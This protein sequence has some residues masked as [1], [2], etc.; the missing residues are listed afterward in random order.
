MD[1]CNPELLLK[2]ACVIGGHNTSLH[3]LIVHWV[4]LIASAFCYDSPTKEWNLTEA[5]RLSEET[6][7]AM[8]EQSN[9]L[10]GLQIQEIIQ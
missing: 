5:Y 1:L 6:E 3:L 8:K 7:Q 10:N 2:L 4:P 9:Q